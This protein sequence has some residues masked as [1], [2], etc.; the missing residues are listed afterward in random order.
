MRIGTGS[1]Q[2]TW[3]DHWANLPDHPSA[4]ENGRTHGVAVTRTGDVV[5]FAQCNPAVLFFDPTGRP[6][7]AWGDRFAGA[8]GLT[9]VREDNTEYLWLVDEKS[10]EVCK[11]TL[12]GK[13]VQSIDKP[14]HPA[15]DTGKYIPTWAAVHP[16]T[17]DIWVADG[18]GSSL[19]HRHDRTGK[20]LSSLDGSEGAGRFNCPHGIMFSPAGE[21]WIADRA[22]R[23]ITIYDAQGKHLRHRDL[24]THSPCGFSFSPDGTR[25]LVP[26]LFTGIK[27]LDTATL[28]CLAELGAGAEVGG[29]YAR[30]WPPRCPQGWPNLAGTPHVQPGHFN[31]PHGACLAPNGDLYCVEWIV[32]GRITKLELAR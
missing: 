1:F 29:D 25:V 13:T 6:K 7:A 20:Y 2:Y 9:L 19:V 30:F 3:H 23:R 21:L 4:R 8:H 12:D 10:C 22:N 16:D 11:T 17:G 26:E 28:D 31:S 24:V 32:G 27:L 14:P 18:Y 5:V 15:Y